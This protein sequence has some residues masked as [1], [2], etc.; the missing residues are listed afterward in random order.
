MYDVYLIFAETDSSVARDLC[1]SLKAIGLEV[2]IY[3]EDISVGRSLN[4]NYKKLINESLIILPIVSDIWLSHESR[5]K[6]LFVELDIANSLEKTV[7]PFLLE[8]VRY[9]DVRSFCKQVVNFP[10]STERRI[11]KKLGA[12]P[13]SHAIRCVL[14]S[15]SRIDGFVID[16]VDAEVILGED[17]KPVVDF[18]GI[19]TENPSLV[20]LWSLALYTKEIGFSEEADIFRSNINPELMAKS[21]GLTSVQTEVYQSHFVGKD[22]SLDNSCFLSDKHVIISAPTSAGKSLL[23]ECFLVRTALLN[24]TRKKAIYVAPTRALAQAKYSELL[25]TLE[26]SPRLQNGL[27]LST[28]EDK[29]TDRLLSSGLFSVACMVYEKANV[30]FSR[31]PRML[32]TTGLVVID[33]IH[34]IE[35]LHRGPALEIMLAKLVSERKR[36]DLNRTQ[37]K[38]QEKIR[39]VAITTENSDSLKLNEL[40][41]TS[42]TNDPI[43]IR[44]TKRPLPVLHKLVIEAETKEQLESFE[45]VKYEDS[46]DRRIS[47]TKI[48]SLD[49]IISSVSRSGQELP[50]RDSDIVKAGAMIHSLILQYLNKYSKG[51]RIL[52]FLPSKNMVEAQASRLRNTLKSKR[53][54]SDCEI[55]F[56]EPITLEKSKKY[57]L[58]LTSLNE[59][60]SK[61]LANK[62]R[63]LAKEGIYVHH[64]DIDRNIRNAI[65]NLCDKMDPHSGTEVIF[66]TTTLAYGVNLSIDLVFLCGYNF[67]SNDRSGSITNEPLSS[68]LYFNMVG[69]SGR[70]GNT[71]IETPEICT[72]IPDPSLALDFLKRYYFSEELSTYD[73]LDSVLY[74]IND[75]VEEADTPMSLALEK[76]YK[77]NTR[78]KENN[79]SYPFLWA[80]LD[81]LRH[82]NYLE[83]KGG[84]VEAKYTSLDTLMNF[85]GENTLYAAKRDVKDLHELIKSIH[86][87]L[88]QCYQHNLVSKPPKSSEQGSFDKYR[89]TVR[90]EAIIDTSTHVVT[91]TSLSKVASKIDKIFQNFFPE[92]TYTPA[93]IHLLGLVLQ[94]E[95]Y[96]D[97]ANYTPECASNR[98]ANWSRMNSEFNKNNIETIFISNISFLLM[99]GRHKCTVD[100]GRIAGF[101]DSLIDVIR[102]YDLNIFG[103]YNGA[104][105]HAIMR[106]YN[107][108][109][110]WIN[111]H[112]YHRVLSNIESFTPLSGND[113]RPNVTGMVSTS[114]SG[115]RSFIE[116]A[117]YKVRFMAK[118]LSLPGDSG[119]ISLEA[120]RGLFMLVERIRLGCVNNAIPL[121]YPKQSNIVRSE[122]S[123]LVNKFRVP[124]D[125]I[126]TSGKSFESLSKDVLDEKKL[127]HLKVDL[128]KF[129]VEKFRELESELTLRGGESK[130]LEIYSLLFR[131]LS[132]NYI[133]DAIVGYLD[134]RDLEPGRLGK[135]VLVCMD[136]GDI[137]SETTD[138]G[139]RQTNLFK[140]KNKRDSAVKLLMVLNSQLPD[141]LLW[142][143]QVL[144][145]EMSGVNDNAKLLEE[146]YHI[147]PIDINQQWECRRANDK[148]V[149]TLVNLVNAEL[150]KNCVYVV[151]PWLPGFANC[152]ADLLE[153][154][155]KNREKSTVFISVSVFAVLLIL[156]ER[157]FIRDVDVLD[158]LT[159]KGMVEDSNFPYITINQVSE[160]FADNKEVPPAI[161]EVFVNHY[162]ANSLRVGKHQSMNSTGMNEI[163]GSETLDFGY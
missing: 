27:I 105:V 146:N 14:D 81:A 151:G 16:K 158:I 83:K 37:D 54:S 73:D 104:S 47:R 159:G 35:D 139:V 98:G 26:N 143:S 39:I 124:A 53:S 138:D 31:N 61:S 148:E 45:I 95:V 99:S 48:K 30:V 1:S 8:N 123:Y 108:I 133:D 134:G 161:L 111:G 23:S 52:V 141:R 136:F 64:S 59:S 113:L 41:T 79:F 32:E 18:T 132:E 88:D 60:E 100:E 7:L 2:Y 85:F 17:W 68:S 91:L 147:I 126:L 107:C 93:E 86:G 57:D 3:N 6:E 29:D 42:K 116:K 24:S 92:K 109:F 77:E 160:L 10:N 114:W 50:G 149:V 56:R 118:I 15:L 12:S 144:S 122:A 34:M 28:G 80:V 102:D 106:I 97:V 11:I 101:V 127:R 162:E 89:I 72:V 140:N 154:L 153:A 155:N 142:K 110:D 157:R 49:K 119:S 55:P 33:E 25:A 120:Q 135:L 58:L 9:D 19:R 84:S 96:K 66:S 63:D 163:M 129:A 67:V 62:I 71:N 82:L 150:D 4:D 22:L 130:R 70:F 36:L 115:F 46:R 13:Y 51:H 87:A 40:L 131:S 65:E 69:R 5:D 74:T 94:E 128:K 76:L 152:P 117:H 75:A 90:G 43:H 103:H 125:I 78:A 156:A 121:F 112:E 38:N 145:D 20:D 137:D 44:S 21:N